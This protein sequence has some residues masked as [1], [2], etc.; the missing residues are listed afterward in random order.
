MAPAEFVAAVRLWLGV[1]GRHKCKV[2]KC[3]G[4]TTF[5]GMKA[6]AAAP[7]GS[8]AAPAAAAAPEGT[9]HT[10]LTGTFRGGL[11]FDLGDACHRLL[12][13]P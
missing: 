5:S 4:A 11:F 2:A 12:V 1:S 13:V 9:S 8:G 6:G 10:R 7:G 3:T